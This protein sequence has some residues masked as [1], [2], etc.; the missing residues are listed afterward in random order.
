MRKLTITH[1]GN[2]F[3]PH[4]GAQ[5]VVSYT[6]LPIADS[7]SAYCAVCKRKMIQWSSSQEPFY[8]LVKRPDRKMT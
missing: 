1:G 3:C 8:K 4:C 7:G 2:F 5:Y 6:Q